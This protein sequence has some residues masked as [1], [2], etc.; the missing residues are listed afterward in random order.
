MI[1]WTDKIY[2]SENIKESKREKI[3]SKLDKGK[4]QR[5]IFCIAA[6]ANPRT[7]F[8]I[9]PAK[10]LFKR[11]YEHDEVKIAGIAKGRAEA[12]EL[13]CRMVETMYAETRGLDSKSYFF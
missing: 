11:F 8:D 1:V 9:I 6:P 2:Y 3:R 7:L 12:E 10:E 5:D 13:V 4:N